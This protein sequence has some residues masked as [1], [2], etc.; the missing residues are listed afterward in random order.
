M[1]RHIPIADA[2][3]LQ[4]YLH[5]WKK[6]ANSER[7]HQGIDG[8]TPEERSKDAPLAEVIDLAPRCDG[9]SSSAALTP[10]GCSRATRW[11]KT[12]APRRLPDRDAHDQ[13]PRA[14]TSRTA[15]MGGFCP[16]PAT[17][18]RA[19]AMGA[20]WANVGAVVALLVAHLVGERGGD[21]ALK[22]RPEGFLG[23]GWRVCGPAQDSN[24]RATNGPR[25]RRGTVR[26]LRTVPA[27]SFQVPEFAMRTVFWDDAN[28]R[29][30]P[31]ERLANGLVNGVER[32]AILPST[33][34]FVAGAVNGAPRYMPRGLRLFLAEFAGVCAHASEPRAW[35]AFARR[36]PRA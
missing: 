36:A 7:P 34:T 8:R 24:R 12:T 26:I 3:E 6:F 1:L 31:A 14:P 35:T 16:E 15:R 32:G 22:A 33:R 21:G 2:K 23:S 4:F 13:D 9:A 10:T 25:V 11:S 18:A 30:C 29:T 19:L 28:L 27:S 5:E 20:S 17:D